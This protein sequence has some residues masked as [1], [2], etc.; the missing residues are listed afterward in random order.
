MLLFSNHLPG[1][2]NYPRAT[3]IYSRL[4]QVALEKELQMANEVGGNPPTRLEQSFWI[5]PDGVLLEI[6]YSIQ[7]SCVKQS[8]QS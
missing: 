3:A 1:G 7:T 6:D 5:P 8:S 4:H 2:F